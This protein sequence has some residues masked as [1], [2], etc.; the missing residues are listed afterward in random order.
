MDLWLIATILVFM[1]VVWIVL[2]P[3]KFLLEQDE[4]YVSK[5]EKKTSSEKIEGYAESGSDTEE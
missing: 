4:E 1:I 5:S 2:N 3:K